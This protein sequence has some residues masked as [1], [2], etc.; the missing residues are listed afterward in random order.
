MSQEDIKNLG[1]TDKMLICIDAAQHS[2]QI[3]S[4]QEPL[5]SSADMTFGDVVPSNDISSETS[6]DI[7]ILIKAAKKALL[8][9]AP[10]E[11]LLILLRYNIIETV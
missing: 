10:R 3:S 7:N 11:R 9:L 2:K 8:S 1:I 6:T 5:S 4:L